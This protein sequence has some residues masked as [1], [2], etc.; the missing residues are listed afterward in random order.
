MSENSQSVKK[1]K[2]KKTSTSPEG[3][4]ENLKKGIT[5]LLVLYL[6]LKKKHLY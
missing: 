6:L 1:G 4:E 2:G 3:L 5:E